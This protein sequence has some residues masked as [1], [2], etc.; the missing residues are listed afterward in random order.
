VPNTNTPR[1]PL[2]AV[3]S[4][5][6]R[7]P[8]F[9]SPAAARSAAV[10]PRYLH[11]KSEP[12]PLAV[13]PRLASWNKADDPEQIRLTEFLRAAEDL[14]RASLQRLPDPLALRL[15]VGL[16]PSVRLLDAH[17]LDNIYSR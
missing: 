15:D 2:P 6:P 1:G 11:P 13:Q 9:T 5:G 10:P 7:S 16:P 14:L 12:F 17:D 4:P 3:G 8:R